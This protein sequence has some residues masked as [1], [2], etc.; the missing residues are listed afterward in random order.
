MQEYRNFLNGK[1]DMWRKAKQLEFNSLDKILFTLQDHESLTTRNSMTLRILGLV[2]P[3]STDEIKLTAVGD[4]LLR[5]SARQKII[6]EQLLKIYLSSQVNP[7]LVIPVYPLG[8]IYSLLSTLESISFEEYGLVVCWIHSDGEIP[9]ALKLIQDYRN[10]DLA[11]KLEFKSILKEKTFSL[12]ISDFEDN[13]YRL[14][15]VFKLSSFISTDEDTPR[16]SEIFFAN[17]EPE[18]YKNLASAIESLRDMDY[19]N[20]VLSEYLGLIKVTSQH[21]NVIS[22]LVEL[23]NEEVNI[24]AKEIN[25]RKALP[26]LMAVSPEQISPT[27]IKRVST[28]DRGNNQGTVKK[29]DYAKRDDRNRLA[30]R[31]G[32]QI[33]YKYEYEKLV[34]TG[35]NDL[36]LKIEHCS[37]TDDT[38][39]YDIK[40][41]DIN[42]QEKHIEVK[43]VKGMPK[44]FTFF[45]SRNEL[46][47]VKEDMGHC[48]YIVF[49]YETLTPKI[50]EIPNIINEF[51]AE[52]ISIEPVKYMVTITIV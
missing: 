13:I 16:K 44:T 15:A 12:N 14:F 23:T 34:N 43:A 49:G 37:E 3:E 31:F 47:K 19:E 52:L 39:G 46:E 9:T 17:S 38:L 1:N 7:K 50:W 42:G 32:E 21:K 20:E 40:S 18:V 4:K 35:K 41:Y 2:Y 30:G 25:E 5:S 8:V 51:D 11:T 26:D 36:A 6:D 48:I 45:I 33:V 29:I 28:K 24:L 27:A 22:R 10:A